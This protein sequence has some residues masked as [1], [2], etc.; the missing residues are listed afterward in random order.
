MLLTP[1]HRLQKLSRY[2]QIIT[3]LLFYGFTELNEALG[4]TRRRVMTSRIS[5]IRKGRRLRRLPFGAR[6]RLLLEELGPTFIKLGQML[7][8]RPDLL[9]ESI[10]AELKKLQ[11]AASPL[12]FDK[13][14]PVLEQALGGEWRS[15][16]RSISS[17]PLASAS[18]AQVHRATTLE[19]EEVVLKIQRPGIADLIRTDL[20]ILFDLASL[21]ERY[22]PRARI[23]KPVRLVDHFARVLTLELDFYYEGRTMDLFR[24]NFRHDSD[25]HIP[26]VDWQLSTGTVLVMEYIE[27]IR[28]SDT[29]KLM[30]QGV[31]T[32]SLAAIG[33]KYVLAQLFDYA[34]YNADPHPAN[35]IVRTDGVLV[36]LDFGMVGTLD[37]EMK[38]ALVTMLLAFVNKNPDKLMRVFFTL[39]LLDETARRTELS[40]DL[41]RLVNYY[42]HI[43]LAHLSIAKIFQDLNAII[44][45]YQITLP[46]DLALT[47]KAVVT[48]ES[49]GKQLDPDFDVIEI[50]R[51]FVERVRLSRLKEWVDPDKI[52]DLFEDTSRFLRSLPYDAHELLKKTRTGKL[53]I[54]L[55]LEDLDPRVREIDRSV[56]RLSFAIVISGLLVSS[57]FFMRIEAGPRLFGLPVLGL[58]GYIAAGVLGIWFLI[59]ILRSGRL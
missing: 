41:S 5:A 28:L 3:R 32:R 24:E 19:G 48:V 22:I 47:L 11:Y 52:F 35:F 30:E 6:L 31:D 12:P 40:Y 15:K 56:N 44:R 9:P 27:G 54:S 1:R 33:T 46:V 25:I 51:P 26:Q 53:K 13:L 23:Y 55:N 50:A 34:V 2:R 49:L 38:Q 59:G 42:H 14:E 20:A 45:R 17:E 43:P 16:L 18:I 4:L 29:E 58:A 10:T 37:E 21:I 8:L 7:S 57:S 36:P 39:D